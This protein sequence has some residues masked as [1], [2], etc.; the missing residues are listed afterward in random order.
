MPAISVKPAKGAKLI[1]S[2]STAGIVLTVLGSL[3]IIFVGAEYL[4]APQSNAADFGVPDWPRS[5]GEGSA[6]LALVAV[7][8]VLLLTAPRDDRT[9]H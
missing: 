1:P 5:S 6:F 8:A 9:E 3:F 7:A 2:R 4:L